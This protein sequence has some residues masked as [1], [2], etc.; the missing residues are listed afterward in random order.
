MSPSALF[1]KPEGSVFLE[2]VYIQ[3]TYIRLK[4][5]RILACGGSVS[6]V[7]S[8]IS[9]ARQSLKG[10]TYLAVIVPFL[11]FLF[12]YFTGDIISYP[13]RRL[14]YILEESTKVQSFDIPI[15]VETINE[16]GIVALNVKRLFDKLLKNRMQLL[17][18]SDVLQNNSGQY[19]AF[20]MQISN[21][22]SD[23]SSKL[24]EV[25]I[26]AKQISQMAVRVAA[27][28]DRIQ[29]YSKNALTL[30]R[31][32]IETFA[33]TFNLFE[34]VQEQMNAIESHSQKLISAS[35]SIGNI[36]DNMQNIS[37]QIN[38][39]SVNAGIEAAEAGEFGLGF[40]VVASE[41]KNLAFES[42]LAARRIKRQLKNVQSAISE[43][44]QSLKK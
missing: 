18:T 30:V 25:S 32:S 21:S 5:G 20:S 28:S 9:L 12:S 13:I 44:G 33:D 38:V 14:S 7:F 10:F 3:L 37:A 15:P 23:Q 39:L 4:D 29:Q 6:R 36:L 2:S 27:E 19:S 41:I 31:D 11:F 42:N 35:E 17:E 8:F 43:T 34:E 40:S 16:F 24:K 1:K 26:A 22:A